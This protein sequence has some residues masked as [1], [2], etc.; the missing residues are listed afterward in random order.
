MND[1]VLIISPH[2]DDGE[3]GCGGTIAKLVDENKTVHYVAL[4]DAKK[5]LLPG[6]PTDTLIEEAKNAVKILGINK[7]YLHFFEFETRCFPQYRQEILDTLYTLK[8]EINP[9][10]I[11]V[12]SLKDVHQDHQVVTI[13]ALRA[14]KNTA[15]TIFGYE[16]PWNCFTFDTT[17]FNV[18]NEEQIQR[19]TNAL[20][21]YKSQQ[22]RNYFNKESVISLAKVRGTQIGVK[23]AEAF[24]IMRMVLP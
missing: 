19:K 6:I 22:H 4:S 13:E 23:Y 14:F 21:E 5:S 1:T 12:P 8:N 3:L 7:N 20:N 16:E 2:I 11:F 9:Q 10:T 24:E 17:V 18:L 15:L